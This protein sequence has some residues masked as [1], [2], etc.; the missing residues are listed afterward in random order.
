MKRLAFIVSALVI[1]GGLSVPPTTVSAT[2]T[3]LPPMSRT[4]DDQQAPWQHLILL[5]RYT[6][7]DLSTQLPDFRANDLAPP[8]QPPNPAKPQTS[9][10]QPPHTATPANPDSSLASGPP[11]SSKL[12]TLANQVRQ[13]HGRSA[14][15]PDAGLQQ[16]AEFKARDMATNNYFSH[17]DKNSQQNNGLNQIR[18]NQPKCSKIAENIHKIRS[19]DATS[20]KVMDGWV[21]SSGHFRILTSGEYQYTGLAVAR[22]ADGTYYS[23][24]HFCQMK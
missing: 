20:Q 19:N 3:P 2:A 22:S 5:M 8:Q 11:Q 21:N 4:T 7:S 15:Q 18:K 23:V 24:Q 16:S 13:Q 1:I 14:L 9:A 6:I 10:P 12:I 17:K